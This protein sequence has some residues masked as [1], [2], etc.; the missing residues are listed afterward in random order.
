MTDNIFSEENNSSQVTIPEGEALSTLVGEDKKFKDLESLAKGKLES[1][2]YIAKLEEN[3]TKVQTELEK[4]S[5]LDDVMNQINQSRQSQEST[6]ESQA[7]VEQSSDQ[8]STEQVDIDKLLESKLSEY[9]KAK[10]EEN[11]LSFAAQELKKIHGDSAQAH[12]NGKAKELGVTVKDLE[13]YAKSNPKVFLSL[14]SG[15]SQGN[16]T[17]SPNFTGS[18]DTSKNYTSNTGE[19]NQSYYNKL[20][21]TDP[22]LYRSPKIQMEMHEQ[23]IKLREN[24]FK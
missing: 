10:Q 7:H 17:Q 15:Q 14:V 4:R 20:K 12:L 9:E 1:D 11:N 23:A 13:S 22:T 6:Q 19:K 21:Q 24:F 16:N 18:V 2:N 5:T 8:G 3:L